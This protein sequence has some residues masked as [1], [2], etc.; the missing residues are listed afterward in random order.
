MTNFFIRTYRKTKFILNQLRIKNVLQKSK[1]LMQRLNYKFLLFNHNIDPWH[2][3]G[4]FHCRIYKKLVFNLVEKYNPNLYID[5]GCG[6]GEI[7]SKVNLKSCNKFGLD[8]GKGLDKSIKKLNQDKFNFFTE[9]NK[10]I[11][12]LSKEN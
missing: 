2:L 7:L 10:L 6:L 4:T 11:D 3:K 1:C 5:I 8:I 12:Y 9:E